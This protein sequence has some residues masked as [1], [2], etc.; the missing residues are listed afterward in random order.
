M[1]NSKCAVHTGS[2]VVAVKECYGDLKIVSFWK[3]DHR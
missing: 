1:L 2:F 3:V